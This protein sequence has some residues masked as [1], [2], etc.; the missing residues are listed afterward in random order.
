MQVDAYLERILSCLS[1]HDQVTEVELSPEGD[2]RPAGSSMPF[3]SV[4]D[5]PSMQHLHTHL[6]GRGATADSIK[7]DPDGADRATAGG[8][9]TGAAATADDDS[10]EESEDELEELRKAASAVAA[11]TRRHKVETEV[12]YL[13]SDSDDDLPPR[14]PAAAART[15]H[16]AAAARTAG[17][18]VASLPMVQP[19]VVTTAVGRGQQPSGA[20]A[21]RQADGS[22]ARLGSHAAAGP[23]PG[24]AATAAA[25]AGSPAG[26]ATVFRGAGGLTIRL[27]PRRS[28][29]G[30]SSSHQPAAAAGHADH[31]HQHQQQQ[32]QQQ[33]VPSLPHHNLHPHSHHHHHHQQQHDQ[34]HL[35]CQQ[36]PQMTLH[37][38]TTVGQADGVGGQISSLQAHH[39]AAVHQQQQQLQPDMGS[40]SLA[41]ASSGGYGGVSVPATA[42]GT[43]P[44]A[45]YQQ[46]PHQQAV[47]WGVSPGYGATTSGGYPAAVT[48]PSHAMYH[49][50][51]QQQQQ[52]QQPPY[53]HQHEMAYPPG[54]AY[55]STQQ[56]T[57]TYPA[58]PS[59]HQPPYSQPPLVTSGGGGY[60]NGYDARQLGVGAAQLPLRYSIAAQPGA[61][62]SSGYVADMQYHPHQQQPG[63]YGQTT[64]PPVYHSAGTDTPGVMTSGLGLLDDAAVGSALMNAG[65][66]E[67]RFDEFI[68]LSD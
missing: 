48:S 26:G 12:I 25:V 68:N 27:P 65:N 33:Q 57:P 59:A 4:L 11:S 37:H 39:H 56:Y 29:G 36:S 53:A 42:A 49:Q 17:I 43:H 20:A 28:G 2:W 24:S 50:L 38:V 5:P 45:Y 30:A 13:L 32:H 35:Q 46:Q 52:Q 34:L 23:G 16:P 58:Y 67:L 40:G 14:A 1:G 22:S 51:Q 61:V 54:A 66:A 31:Q 44:P 60:A 55:G 15:Q 63:R 19:Q 8:H 18:P 6:A 41:T 3:M 64:Q 10:D 9:A 62:T 21:A 7:P 47:G